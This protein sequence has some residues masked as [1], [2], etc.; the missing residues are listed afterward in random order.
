[1]SL[2]MMI[3]MTSN[4]FAQYAQ[5]IPWTDSIKDVPFFQMKDSNGQEGWL[6]Y[7][8]GNGIAKNR[9]VQNY[10][11][12]WNYCGEDGFL[13]KNTWVHDSRD[14]KYY[15]LGNDM[16]MLHDTTTPGGYTVGSDGAWIKDG[17]VVVETVNDDLK[18]N[19]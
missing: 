12:N 7:E 15:Y 18:T 13:L 9:W 19:K 17:Q 11:Y 4:A 5:P 8:E 1:M 10:K 16:V 14:G 2:A 3:M 6:Y